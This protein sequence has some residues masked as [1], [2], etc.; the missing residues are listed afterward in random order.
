MTRTSK[1][2]TASCRCG[3]MKFNLSGPPIVRI[4]CYCTSCQTAGHAFVREFG[5]PSIV[6]DDGGSDL[7]LYRKDRV[8]QISG[9]GLLREHRLAP[10]SSTRRMIATCCGTPMAMDFTKGHWLSFY[11]AG[12]PEEGPAHEMRVMTQDKPA[13]VTLPND[14]PLHATR[15]GSLMW[16][17]VLAWGAMG[18]RRPKLPW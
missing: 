4:A 3:Q 2:I 10:E 1:S 12:L 15:S 9:S 18:F 11:R 8:T 6:A 14:V 7:V 13:A 17:L 16:K 5:P